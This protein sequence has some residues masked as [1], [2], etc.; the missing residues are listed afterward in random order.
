[1]EIKISGAMRKGCL[2]YTSE[3]TGLVAD[4]KG[5]AGDGPLVALRADIDAL[6]IREPEGLP[7]RSETDGVMHACGHDTH[8][9][10]LLGAVK[11]LWDHRSEW[12]GTCLLYTSHRAGDGAVGL[13]AADI[14]LVFPAIPLRVDLA[15]TA[16]QGGEMCIRDR[17]YPRCRRYPD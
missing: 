7:F 1:M 2:L 16:G 4:L 11:L 6:P 17:P 10:M 12:H 15:V 14:Q 5:E 13:D 3:P 9:A 8:M